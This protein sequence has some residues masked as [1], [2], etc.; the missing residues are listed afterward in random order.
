MDGGHSI[1]VDGNGNVYVTGHSLS[2]WQG[3]G[4]IDPLHGH[5]GQYDIVL[6]KL[7]SKGVY[8]WHTFYGGGGGDSGDGV[9]VDANGN[10]YV[11]GYSTETWQGDGDVNPIHAYS[12][13]N[14]IFVL[15]LNEQGDYQ[16][17][18][19]YGGVGSDW[20]GYKGIAVDRSG[21]VYATGGSSQWQGDGGSDPLNPYTGGLEIFLLHLDS[22]GAY[23]WHTF[24]GSG[25]DDYG[26]SISTDK[27][28]NIYLTGG[29]KATWQ[30]RWECQSLKHA[31]SSDW[32]IVVLK[33]ST[34]KVR[35]QAGTVGTEIT[36]TGSGFGNKGKQSPPR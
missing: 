26:W 29:S 36:I 34:V 25:G 20:P 1:A 15:K 27:S 12:G 18:T 6:L 4:G 21:N 23:R 19:F 8:Q 31:Y 17:H 30:G 10:V 5:T 7:N 14:D 16:W 3:A 33:L 11:T 9:G 35:P 24:Y 32:D 22:N 28:R 13:G 2:S